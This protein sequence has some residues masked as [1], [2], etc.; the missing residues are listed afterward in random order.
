LDDQAYAELTI[1]VDELGRML[2]TCI[3]KLTRAIHEQ[4]VNR[5]PFGLRPAP[6][7]ALAQDE[8]GLVLS[9]LLGSASKPVSTPLAF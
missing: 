1:E 5:P 2:T 9:K 3:Q 8:P 7:E 6:C 4:I